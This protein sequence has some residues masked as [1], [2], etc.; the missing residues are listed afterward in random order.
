MENQFNFCDYVDIQHEEL[1][2][3]KWKL[4]QY[5]IVGEYVQSEFEIIVNI[6]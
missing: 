6:N 2:S 5:N 3:F 1:D 4:W